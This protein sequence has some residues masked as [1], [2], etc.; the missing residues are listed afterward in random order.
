MKREYLADLAV[1]LTVVQAKGFTQAAA[2]LRTSQSAVS[3]AVRRLKEAL[4][5]RLL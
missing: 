4:G 2:Q 5:I 1:F 3:L